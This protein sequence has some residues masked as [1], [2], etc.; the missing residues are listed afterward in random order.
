M[1]T[2]WRSLGTF[3]D[4]TWLISTWVRCFGHTASSLKGIVDARIRVNA[5]IRRSTGSTDASS[6]ASRIA[7]IWSVVTHQGHQIVSLR[8]Q[9]CKIRNKEKIFLNIIS[10]NQKMVN[11]DRAVVGNTNNRFLVRSTN[12]NGNESNTWNQSLG[13]GNR[14]SQVRFAGGIPFFASNIRIGSTFVI[15]ATPHSVHRTISD[16]NQHF[17]NSS[18]W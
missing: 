17:R 14:G 7:R 13:V 9:S 18:S 4:L 1:L 11:V 15:N 3:G 6:T 5:I 16:Q 2:N 10:C 12:T 8:G